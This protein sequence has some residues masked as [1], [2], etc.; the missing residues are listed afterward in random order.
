MNKSESLSILE[1]VF[2]GEEGYL[3]KASS[4]N[5]DSKT[6]NA[7]YNNYTKYWRDIADWGLGNYQAQYWCAGFVHW[8]FVTAFGLAKAKSLLLHAPYISCQTLADK[9]N[10]AGRRYTSPQAGDVVIFWNGSRFRHTGYVITVSSTTFTTIEGNT[11]SGSSVVANGGGV[12]QKSYNTANATKT[13]HR[14]HRPDYTGILGTVSSESGTNNIGTTNNSK[15]ANIG[16][17]QKWLNAEYAKQIKEFCGALLIVDGAYG[18]FTRAACLAVF[19]DVLNRKHGYKLDPSN[20]NFGADTK[21]ASVSE[22][23]SVNSS[24]TATLIVQLILSAKG[25]YN[26]KMDCACGAQTVQAIK[27]FQ[28]AKGLSADGAC[29][30]DTWYAL[31]N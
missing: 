19:K 2:K 11:S 26:G 17:G 16:T 6:A 12:Y 14:F 21:A 27:D 15:T 28:K 23:V 13:G 4:A 30:K 9:S 7:G 3:E 5:L 24:G 10:S 1:S 8:C 29:G 22:T 31:F 20:T 18:V 25:Y